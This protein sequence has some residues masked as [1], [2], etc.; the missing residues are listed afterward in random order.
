MARARRLRILIEMGKSRTTK[1][2][3]GTRI[4]GPFRISKY[5]IDVFQYHMFRQPVIRIL[6]GKEVIAE[7]SFSDIATAVQILSG[8]GVP[9]TIALKAVSIIARKIGTKIPQ[10][11]LPRII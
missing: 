8:Q 10:I 6:W 4:L 9:H 1:S 3:S 2:G 7:A 11:K 5:R